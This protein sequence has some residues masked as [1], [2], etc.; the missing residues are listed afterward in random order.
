MKVKFD[1]FKITGKWYMSWNFDFPDNLDIYHLYL[2]IDEYMNSISD[3]GSKFVIAN[4]I[5]H[6][7]GFQKLYF[8]KQF[9]T[10]FELFE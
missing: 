6:N 3:R 4:P 7:M 2:K 5:E 10:F 1:S 9:D 8:P